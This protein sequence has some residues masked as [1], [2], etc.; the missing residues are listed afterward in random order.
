MNP[1]TLALSLWF[2]FYLINGPSPLSV[3]IRDKVISLLHPKLQYMLS[4]SYCF[5]SWGSLI[6]VLLTQYPVYFIFAAAAL[7]HLINLVYLSLTQ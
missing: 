4:C 6:V 7:T 2:F 5:G 1:F 3:W